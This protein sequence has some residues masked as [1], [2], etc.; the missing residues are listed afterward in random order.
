[1]AAVMQGSS[2]YGLLSVDDITRWF[3][4]DNSVA[5]PVY[6][7]PIR[8]IASIIPGRT[9]CRGKDEIVTAS[10][11]AGAAAFEAV[12]DYDFYILFAHCNCGKETICFKIKCVQ[13]MVNVI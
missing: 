10:L 9:I 4:K 1:M 8:N 7:L 13:V 5:I 3:L 12:C 11:L 2:F 6:E